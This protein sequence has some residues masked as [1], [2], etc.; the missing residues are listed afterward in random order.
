MIE[1]CECIL[2]VMILHVSISEYNDKC[3]YIYELRTST[4]SKRYVSAC[5]IPIL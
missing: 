2:K 5:R 3:K 4:R 1:I